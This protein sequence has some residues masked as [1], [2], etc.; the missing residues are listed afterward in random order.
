MFD[1]LV[2]TNDI[3]K[4]TLRFTGKVGVLASEEEDTPVAVTHQDKYREVGLRT[5]QFENDV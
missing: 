1:L 5:T 3:M 2:I 4:K